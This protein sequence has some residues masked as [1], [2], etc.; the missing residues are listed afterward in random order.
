M[1]PEPKRQHGRWKYFARNTQKEHEERKLKAFD[2]ISIKS[3]KRRI[4][5]I[6]SPKKQ[7]S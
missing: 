3:K 1:W 7:L 4:E 6:F 5:D 2:S